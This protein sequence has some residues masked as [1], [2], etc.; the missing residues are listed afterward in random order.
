MP[1]IAFD[2]KSFHRVSMKIEGRRGRDN[3]SDNLTLAQCERILRK[4]G[5]K[6]IGTDAARELAETLEQIGTT[7]AWKAAERVQQE[8]RMTMK[9]RDI[10]DA[11]KVILA[12]ARLHGTPDSVG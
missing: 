6:R 12:I 9:S 10:T 4:S 2:G 11:S 7:I 8:G 5:V 3:M 1:N